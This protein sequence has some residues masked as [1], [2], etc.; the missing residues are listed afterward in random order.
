V[1]HTRRQD[2]SPSVAAQQAAAQDRRERGVKRSAKQ[3][4]ASDRIPEQIQTAF[5]TGLRAACSLNAYLVAPTGI[6]P[7]LFALR[8]RRVNQ[9]HH[10]AKQKKLRRCSLTR[11]PKVYQKQEPSLRALLSPCC[12]LHSN[13]GRLTRNHQPAHHPLQSTKSA[14]SATPSTAAPLSRH[15]TVYAA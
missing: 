2:R 5:Q 12:L 15:A 11:L 3:I 6:E 9:L 7:V 14:P 13:S 8:G 10:G 1:T 4:E